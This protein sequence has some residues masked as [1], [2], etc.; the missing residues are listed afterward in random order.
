MSG[1][2][3]AS[4]LVG[5]PDAEGP[6]ATRSQPT[7]VAAKDASRSDRCS[8]W[9]AV[10]EAGEDAMAI[11]GANGLAVGTWDQLDPLGDGDPFLV[12]AV[13]PSLSLVA[14]VRLL[15]RMQRRRR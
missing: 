9:V 3:E 13:E 14:H 15:S 2:A 11:E 10:V 12:G 4:D 5:K 6:S 1:Q 7:T 8:L